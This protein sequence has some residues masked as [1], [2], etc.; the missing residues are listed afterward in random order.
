MSFRG[1]Y[2]SKFRRSGNVRG[3]DGVI[4][5]ERGRPFKRKY[6]QGREPHNIERFRGHGP[7]RGRGKIVEKEYFS[8]RGRSRPF[9]K[10]FSGR[11]LRPARSRGRHFRGRQSHF[12]GGRGKFMAPREYDEESSYER[13]GPP[14]DMANE[15]EYVEDE[16]AFDDPEDYY[17][18]EDEYYDRG[19]D[20]PPFEHRMRSPLTIHRRF[21]DG[22]EFDPSPER[23]PDRSHLRRSPS[24]E[25]RFSEVR[26]RSIERIRSSE[27]RFVRQQS[28]EQDRPYRGDS[29]DFNEYRRSPSVDERGI[30]LEHQ[31]PI[32]PGVSIRRGERE[33]SIEYRR[34]SVDRSRSSRHSRERSLHGSDRERSIAGSSRR[35]IE[36]QIEFE[37]RRLQQML[38]EK[39]MHEKRS[40]SSIERFLDDCKRSF[41]NNPKSRSVSPSNSFEGRGY[42][43]R[44]YIRSPERSLS[45]SNQ[46]RK[47]HGLKN[48]TIERGR[49]I[50]RSRSPVRTIN[51]ERRIEYSPVRQISP[52]WREDVRELH[53]N[54]SDS[55]RR[56]R[57]RRH[58]S[59]ERFSPHVSYGR[60]S[61]E[62]SNSSSRAFRKRA[63]N[64]GNEERPFLE[65][66]RGHFLGERKRDFL[67]DQDRPFLEEVRTDFLR[68]SIFEPK[69]STGYNREMSFERPVS[70][71]SHDRSYKDNR[72]FLGVGD[73]PF[74]ENRSI[75]IQKESLELS[76]V[77]QTGSLGKEQF[78]ASRDTHSVKEMELSP[79]SQAGSFEKRDFSEDHRNNRDLSPISPTE[80]FVNLDET[81]AHGSHRP[82]STDSMQKF[83]AELEE[84]DSRD[85]SVLN[86]LQKEHFGKT[87]LQDIPVKKHRKK[88]F[89]RETQNTDKAI[90]L[91]N[92]DNPKDNKEDN[93]PKS[94]YYDFKFTYNSS[95][96][97]KK[98]GLKPS[99]EQ[100]KLFNAYEKSFLSQTCDAFNENLF[101]GRYEQPSKTKTKTN[102]EST[103]FQKTPV[104]PSHPNNAPKLNPSSVLPIAQSN[105]RPPYFQGHNNN[106]RSG[107]PFLK[108]N[109]NMP[110]QMP[111]NPS[112]FVSSSNMNIGPVR[113]PVY[114]NQTMIPTYP[115]QQVPST[116]PVIP[117]ISFQQ[118]TIPLDQ[119][120]AFS[121]PPKDIFE[122]IVANPMYSRRMNETSNQ[123]PVWKNQGLQSENNAA[124]PSQIQQTNQFQKTYSNNNSSGF[125]NQSL[126]NRHSLV[127]ESTNTFSNH[128]PFQGLSQNLQ[129]DFCSENRDNDQFHSWPQNSASK[130][131][132]SLDKPSSFNDRPA[133]HKV[134]EVIVI[135]DDEGQSKSQNNDYVYKSDGLIFPKAEIINKYK[136]CSPTFDV[137][138]KIF[139][140][141]VIYFGVQANS[142]LQKDPIEVLKESFSSSE[143]F[144]RLDI[145]E[146]TEFKPNS[147]RKQVCDLRWKGV[148]LSRAEGDSREEARISAGI[149]LINALAKTCFTIQTKYGYYNCGRYPRFMLKHPEKKGYYKMVKRDEIIKSVTETVKRL[150]AKGFCR[151]VDAT[152]VN[153]VITF[154]DEFFNDP[155]NHCELIFGPSSGMEY[156]IGELKTIGEHAAEKGFQRRWF[157]GTKKVKVSGRFLCV[158]RRFSP[159][160]LYRY[161]MTEMGDTVRYRLFPPQG[162][163]IDLLTPGNFYS[164][165]MIKTIQGVGYKPDGDDFELDDSFEDNTK[166]SL[167][168]DSPNLS[169][170]PHP[171]WSN[172]GLS[173]SY[174]NTTPQ[175][176]NYAPNPVPRLPMLSGPPFQNTMQTGFDQP[177]QGLS[178][179]PTFTQEGYKRNVPFEESVSKRGKWY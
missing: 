129:T 164:P 87:N 10:N 66:Q 128:Q 101:Q 93:L 156:T 140:G 73:G 105:P 18:E 175:I 144:E 162:P 70:K 106:F 115:Y 76:P 94:S 29:R 160:A 86:L 133:E 5:K 90:K 85:S 33:R 116:V 19:E 64:Y 124:K 7:I 55:G 50:E 75:E 158:S 23:S 135:S 150:K 49:S 17:E 35:S 173:Q 65:E 177:F 130:G 62:S 134:K 42:S 119:R 155:N 102:P 166:P 83:L 142:E 58:L 127:N 51:Y 147:V 95:L 52:A 126:Q 82:C 89:L 103:S 37:K 31:R 68:K 157:H 143:G 159:Q 97:K 179:I 44:K 138:G 21:D 16:E 56:S 154:M 109:L 141:F 45:P 118:N 48:I 99:N 32:S 139:K 57:S 41:E 26:E 79:I 24:L 27:E 63:H 25:R 54:H 6:H 46:S 131:Q 121:Q 39:K 114:P 38:H 148:L 59:P 145:D 111:Q 12:R 120:A 4:L 96:D 161:L 53:E 169:N 172:Q 165:N 3:H 88:K 117:P 71:S 171:G 137:L 34:H 98:D 123:Q 176:S 81:K 22:E 61:P 170:Q 104:A 36:R 43:N 151:G 100:E 152:H 67:E 163:K 80:N 77:S 107:P 47:F 69:E 30:F 146:M 14:H 174:P 113:T 108:P 91:S 2:P 92:A 60:R 1:R 13:H 72:N 74:T 20:C 167:D 9:R 40:E 168:F 11:V 28:V 178:T 110:T 8:D 132:F 78:S 15:N 84:D 112:N 125:L 136:N 122:N 149:D 153:A